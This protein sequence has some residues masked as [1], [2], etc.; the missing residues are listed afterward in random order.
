MIS[1][2]IEPIEDVVHELIEIIPSHYTELAKFRDHIPLRPDW[3][4][5]IALDRLGEMFTVVCRW[6]G[7]IAAYYIV[8]VRHHLHYMETL[9][10]MMDVCYIRP[11]VRERGLALP[12]FRAAERELRRRRA[13]VWV[14]GYKTAVP[15]GMDK[16]LPILGFEPG[17]TQMVKWIG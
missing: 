9:T 7:A 3:P 14:S 5:Y 2:T 1:F 6:D 13:K 11:G 16:L 8:Y 15:L 12:L 4:K 10:A 17:D